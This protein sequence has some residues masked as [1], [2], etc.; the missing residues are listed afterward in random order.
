MTRQV[1]ELRKLPAPP[2]ANDE[3]MTRQIDSQ[4]SKGARTHRVGKG[5]PL[6]LYAL[7]Y[8]WTPSPVTKAIKKKFGQEE[9]Q[10]PMFTK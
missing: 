4:S 2:G 10:M 3:W 9:V 1:V 8:I 7:A 6:E 5:L